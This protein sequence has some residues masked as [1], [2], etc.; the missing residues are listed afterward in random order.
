MSE[1]VNSVEVFT[2]T[3]PRD[4]P[5]LG[6]ARPGEEPNAKGYLVRKGNR[7]VYP[8]FDR[9]I[10][11]R[12]KTTGGTIGWGETYGLVAPGAVG[13][14][15]NDLLADFTIGRDPS[16]PAAIYDDLYDL[17]RVRGYT[18]GF[19]VDA[20]AAIDIALWDIAG[21]L[22]QESVAS[23]L[24]GRKHE[25]IP[26]YISGLPE[27]TTEKRVALAQS[28]Q[29]RGFNA[30]KFAAPVADDGPVAE[31]AALRAGLGP[32]A[33]IAADMHWNQTADEAIELIEGMA[34]HGLWF[35]EAPVRTEDI[36]GLEK[37]S[38]AT[39]TPTAVGE[40]WRTHFDMQHRVERCDIAIVQPE[41]GHKGITNFVRIGEL[42]HAHR[43]DVIPHATIG[44][45]I[46]LA[47]SI[48]ASSA[49]EA[50]TFHEFQHSIFEPNRRLLKGDMDCQNGA[51]VPPT[52]H[53][54]GVELSEEAIA[55]LKPL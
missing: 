19:Y 9:S 27:D 31:I 43:I 13:E 8:T 18:G 30:F 55:L 45:G 41:M 16:D 25:T 12:I 6:A 17:M 54:L 5:Y 2:L 46:F 29:A 26:A 52:G 15:I 4:V 47:A 44:S 7:T 20:L 48:Q 50:T 49:L 33:Q 23:L 38:K 28:W 11:V 42:A 39:K 24:G 14:L 32:D 37:V 34:A 22:A 1:T 21:K 51:Y 36:A 3:L 10:L 53:G 40:E 35:A